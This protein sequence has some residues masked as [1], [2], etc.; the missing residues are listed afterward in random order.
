MAD[1]LAKEASELQ[2]LIPPN[3]VTTCQDSHDPARGQ[4]KHVKVEGNCV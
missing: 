1:K 3:H 4:Q 2:Q